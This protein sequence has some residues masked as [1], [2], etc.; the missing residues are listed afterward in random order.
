MHT[1]N[2]INLLQENQEHEVI[3]FVT[4]KEVAHEIKTNINT[5]KGPG[6]DLIT[7]EILKQIPRKGIVK[8]THLFNA[9][10]RLKHV[11]SIWKVAEVIMLPKPGK[12]PNEINS[13]I[14]LL[15]FI[16]KLFKK[17]LVK[18]LKPIIKGQNLL[19]NHQFDL[20]KNTL[21]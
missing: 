15:P 4:P 5:K 10:I 12:P 11:P 8:L 3:N 7:G 17:L 1:T 18:R 20:D 16:S 2:K 9:A 21:P 6:F 14:S 19:S 13:Y